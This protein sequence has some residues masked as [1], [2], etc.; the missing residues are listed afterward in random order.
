MPLI[1]KVIKQKSSEFVTNA[2]KSYF[3]IRKAYTTKFCHAYQTMNL[4]IKIYQALL[5]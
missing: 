3:R 2:T 1:S 5:Y 4:G